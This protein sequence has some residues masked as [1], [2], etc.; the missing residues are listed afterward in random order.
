MLLIA[1]NRSLNEPLTQ[2]TRLE[3]SC[4]RRIG[5]GSN[6]EMISIARNFT[7]NEHTKNC[8]NLAG[9]ISVA[10]AFHQKPLQLRSQTL[11]QKSGSW[12]K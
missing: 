11:G 12:D 8:L 6:R 4:A 7:T 5:A 2:C 10:T 9:L 1:L 3:N